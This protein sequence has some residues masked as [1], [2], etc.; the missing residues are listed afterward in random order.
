MEGELTSY[1]G[2][3]VPVSNLFFILSISSWITLLITSWIPIFILANS[4]NRLIA[5]FWLFEKGKY[6][7]NYFESLFQRALDINFIVFKII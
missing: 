7:L 6:V 4:K 2:E 1:T 5:Y 3:D